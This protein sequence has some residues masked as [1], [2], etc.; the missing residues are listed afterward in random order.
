MTKPSSG[1]VLEPRQVSLTLEFPLSWTMLLHWER[2]LRIPLVIF[3]TLR[4]YKCVVP[5]KPSPT[6]FWTQ[7]DVTWL[8]PQ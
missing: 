2:Q 4:G 1:R 3:V 5:D 6:W 7:I 8:L